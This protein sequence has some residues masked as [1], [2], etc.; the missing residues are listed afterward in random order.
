MVVT[1]ITRIL[2]QQPLRN[3]NRGRYA[4]TYKLVLGNTLSSTTSVQTPDPSLPVGEYGHRR[5]RCSD[6]IE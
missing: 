6:R 3:E 5:I 2:L 1:F 4:K